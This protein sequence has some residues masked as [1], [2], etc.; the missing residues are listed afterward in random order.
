MGLAGH[1]RQE[2]NLSHRKRRRPVL[3]NNWEVTEFDFTEDR[4]LSLAQSGAELGI[5]LFVM[6]DGWFGT[7]N[8]D[9]SGLGDWSVNLKKLPS[10]LAGFSQKLRNMGMQFG[11]WIEPEMVNEDSDLYRA[12]PD[13]S[14]QIPGRSPN[15]ERC[16]LVLNLSL[17]EIREYL[18]DQISKILD[19][20]KASYVKWDMNRNL[21]DIW[22]KALPSERQKETAHRYVL[23]LYDLMERLTKTYPDILWE[24]CSGGGGR[25]DAGI[26][27]YMPQIWC[28]DNTDA[29]ER[30]SIQY[31][32][33]FGYPICCMGAHVSDSPN[34]QTGRSVSFATRAEVAMAGTFGYELDV[35][36]LTEEERHQVRQ[37]ISDYKTN[38]YL[39]Q[40]GDYYR[41]TDPAKDKD[42]AAWQF[43]SKDGCESL[44]SVIFL[45]VKA[46][47]PF[48]TIKGKGLMEDA[49]YQIEGDDKIY[50]GAALMYGGIPL[51]VLYGEYPNIHYHIRRICS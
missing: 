33:S 6:D 43:V 26:L 47:P 46:N 8:H 42:Y 34:R 40:T 4:L 48:L 14:I 25:F 24:G 19:E 27:Y 23:G 1:W 51:P 29:V 37:Q 41:L 17:A 11:I 49:V 20:S 9:K 35:R 32:T 50:T 36:A 28:S 13:W 21:S 16:Q 15:L 45:H 2:K 3:L 18:F 39:I 5:E 44:I 7:R 12:H 30:I 31:G 38:Y 22:S 10:G